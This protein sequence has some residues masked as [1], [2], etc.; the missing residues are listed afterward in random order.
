MPSVDSSLLNNLVWHALQGPHAGFSEGGRRAA[1]YR[2]DVAIFAGLPDRPTAADWDELAAL[3]EPGGVATLLQPPIEGPE[4]WTRVMVVPATQMVAIDVEGALDPDVVVLGAGDAGEMMALVEVTK[5]GP[6]APRTVE[7]GGYVGYRAADGSLVAMAGHRMR[8]PGFVEVSAVC[9]EPG[10]RGQGLA[11]RLVRHVVAGAAE[12]GDTVMLHA[13]ATNEGAI[14]L[15]ERM[16]FEHR[17][18]V[19]AVAFAPPEA[20]VATRPPIC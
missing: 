10:S 8:V 14:R 15:Y 16:G 18:D 3:V 6:F 12:V 17:C 5:P 19:E 4:N 11:E 2:P 9:T 20:P 1:R 13:M 7:L